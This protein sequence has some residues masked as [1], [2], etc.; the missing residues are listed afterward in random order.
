MMNSRSLRRRGFTLVELMVVIVIVAS[1]AS[2]II[3]SV[4][5]S[6]T[7]G[8][9]ARNRVDITQL[10]VALEQFKQRF[11][12]YPPSRIKLCERLSY[13]DLTTT[14]SGA[15]NNQLDYDSVQTLT[16]MFPRIDTTGWTAIGIDWNGNG[17]IDSFASPLLPGMDG[18]GAI[19]LEGDQCLVFF[20]GGIPGAGPSCLGFAADP[21]NPANSLSTDRIGP[22]FEFPSSRLGASRFAS[23][24]YNTYYSYADT[25]GFPYAYFSAYKVRNGYNRY[26]TCTAPSYVLGIPFTNSD[27]QTTL[28]VSPYLQT[29]VQYHKPTS[30]Q[31]MSAGADNSFAAGGVIWT[32][33]S[34]P[35]ICAQG[36]SGYDDQAN[37][38]SGVLGAGVE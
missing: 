2:L 17:A 14:A 18:P 37:F 16:S 21:K 1:L 28:G 27:C 36:T 3:A 33:Q 22:F 6:L 11:G 8:K 10:E 29:A 20:L 32:P 9:E 35:S 19:T 30:F 24:A 38:T 34:V 13:Y 23:N 12:M 26:F 7:K 15:P 4:I 25:F 5:G 31:I